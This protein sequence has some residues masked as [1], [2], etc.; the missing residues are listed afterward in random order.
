MPND[1]DTFPETLK[2]YKFHGLSLDWSKS[3]KDA[4]AECPFC[5]KTKFS[6]KVENGVYRCFGCEE[7]GNSSVF[8]QK[9]YA[10]AEEIGTTTAQYETLRKDRKLLSVTPLILWGVMR[11]PLLDE[12][13]LPGFNAE[14]KLCN[15]YRYMTV[16]GKKRLAATST[17][18]HQL[19]IGSDYDKKKEAVILTEGPWDAMAIHEVL[20]Q[21]KFDETDN[22]IET[23]DMKSSLWS[24][25]NIIAIPGCNSFKEAWNPLFS[26]KIVYIAFDN[27]HPRVN[28]K[29][30]KSV[31]PAGLEGVK[32]TVKLLS[33][34]KEPP[35]EIRYLKWGH[36]HYNLELPSGF[37]V[38]D[39]LTTL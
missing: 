35:L 7:K 21:A 4:I 39:Q 31:P 24:D 28:P 15:L 22:I 32:R 37:D 3:K 16:E 26:G 11:H 6:V 12:W 29:N 30:G 8:V 23:G 19:F 5:G 2:P 34:S 14:S 27:D 38:R 1:Q 33:Q 13:M 25:F 10:L 17:I 9:L 20:S 18:G 36:D